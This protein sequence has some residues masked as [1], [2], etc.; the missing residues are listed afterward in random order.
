M[1]H[2]YNYYKLE[3][4]PKEGCPPK[5]SAQVRMSKGNFEGVG[6]IQMGEAVH[7]TTITLHIILKKKCQ[8]SF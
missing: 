8:M 2:R 7:I 3:R 6:E 1:E 5:V 4:I